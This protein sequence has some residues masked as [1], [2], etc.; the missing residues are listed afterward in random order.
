M[1][2]SQD[3]KFRNIAYIVSLGGHQWMD[4]ATPW[5]PVRAIITSDGKQRV[6]DMSTLD[7]GLKINSLFFSELINWFNK[8]NR[9][10][11]ELSLR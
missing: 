6:L 7:F 5:T 11:G 3:A 9:G 1:W 4:I 10:N 8:H 2:P